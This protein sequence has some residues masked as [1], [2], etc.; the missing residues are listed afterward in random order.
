[1]GG[2]TGKLTHLGFG[3]ET[4]YGTGVGATA[5]L[6]Y[7]SETLTHAIEDL[8][9][10]SL[11]ARRFESNNIEGLNTVTGDT[12]HEVH[13]AGLGYILRSAFGSPETTDN[14]GSYTHVYT[15]LATRARDTGTATAGTSG[16]QII[17]STKSWSVDQHN[18]RW[19]HVKTGTGAGAYGY[20]TDTVAT[21]ITVTTSPAAVSTDTY[22]ILDGPENSVLPS[23]SIESHKDLTGT[24]PAFRYSGCVIN[25]LAFNIATGAKI[26]SATASWL[27]KTTTNITETTPNLPVTSPF[28]WDNL[29][30]G[31]GL[32]T[33]GT[34][35]GGSAT[36]LVHTAAA[37]TVNAYS[38]Y[39]VYITGGTGPNQIRKIS[40]NTADTLTISPNWTVNVATGSTYKIFIADSLS[41]DLNFSFSNGLVPTPTLNTTN[42][43][44][45]IESDAYRTGAISRT[46]IP[47]QITDFSTYFQ[48]WTTRE[49]LLWF[50]GAAITGAHYYDL[51]V[52]LPRVLFL[53]Y[54]INVGGPGPLRVATGMKVEYDSTL[55]SMAKIT[56]QNNTS[57]YA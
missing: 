34:A 54:P 33:S 9:P 31:V 42:T 10:A 18:G 52:Y 48:G 14:T 7:T 19:V 11:L 37:W 2:T 41:T 43:I 5:Y 28:T 50:H 21:T 24:T 55:A 20:I 45:R 32:A 30:L 3:K 27:G 51:A 35:T 29:T 25:N 8:I 26:L 23:Y 39:L 53:T 49:W 22:E 57:T 16:S 13:P 47:E 46:I 40:S 17:D 36:T 56:L 12:V 4:V 1:M 6:P 44:Y 38:G 15:A